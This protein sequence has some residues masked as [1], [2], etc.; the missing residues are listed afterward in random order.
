MIVAFLAGFVY[1]ALSVWFSVSANRGMA[2]CAATFSSAQAAALVCG[3][4]RVMHEPRVAGAFV[5]GYGLGS[6]VAVLI[7]RRICRA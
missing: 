6:Y 5:L 3:I 4:E 7:A 1:E 2:I